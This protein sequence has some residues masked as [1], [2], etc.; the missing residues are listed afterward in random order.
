MRFA[1]RNRI[2]NVSRS[3]LCSRSADLNIICFGSNAI[4][5]LCW[6][7]DDRVGEYAPLSSSRG[8]RES[9]GG[10]RNILLAIY[11]I[12][13]RQRN[14]REGPHGRNLRFRLV[15]IYIYKRVELLVLARVVIQSVQLFLQRKGEKHG[16]SFCILSPI[17]S[18]IY[19]D[20]KE[21]MIFRTFVA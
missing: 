6:F 13:L 17:V 8:S 14:A 7:F 1:S 21:T 4:E 15:Y 18:N 20:L 9:R 5:R 3:R 2:K 10:T 11:I 19:V 16:E 12:A